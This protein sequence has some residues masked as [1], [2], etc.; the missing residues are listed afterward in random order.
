MY[1]DLHF[2]QYTCHC[3]HKYN[4]TVLN[5]ETGHRILVCSNKDHTS[6][7]S[8]SEYVTMIEFF[9]TFYTHI[10]NGKVICNIK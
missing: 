7:F 6:I 9:N 3:G 5:D 10:N 4:K 8:L 2:E 1:I